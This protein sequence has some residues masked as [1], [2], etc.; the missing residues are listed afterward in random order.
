MGLMEN[1]TQHTLTQ[2]NR[3]VTSLNV[4]VV[5]VFMYTTTSGALIF[6]RN[7]DNTF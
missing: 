5:S 3:S 4:F 7:G 2:L 1:Q 6:A